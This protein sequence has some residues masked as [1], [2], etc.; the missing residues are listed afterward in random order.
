MFIAAESCMLPENLSSLASCRRV[1][2]LLS[3]LRS[4]IRSTI[5]FRQSRSSDEAAASLSMT[6][7]TS[8]GVGAAGAAFAVVL[9]AGGVDAGAGAAL[10]A[11]P[12]LAPA[13]GTADAELVAVAP[14]RIDDMMFPNTD[15][16]LRSDCL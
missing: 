2:R 15:I 16:L 8:T 5:D 7:A 14:P 13:G 4:F 11:A 3:S 1:V 10:A 6:A 9:D 12:G